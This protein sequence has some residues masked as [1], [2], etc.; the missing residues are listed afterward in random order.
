MSVTDPI[1]GSVGSIGEPFEAEAVLTRPANTDSYELENSVA[2][3][4]PAAL[5]FAIPQA[6]IGDF[7]EIQ[8]VTI[9]SDDKNAL[10]PLILELFLLDTTATP[11]ADGAPFVLSDAENDTAVGVVAG[12]TQ[13]NAGNNVRLERKE[14]GIL[15]KLVSTSLFGLLKI[16]GEYPPVLSEVYT[17][18][19]K[20]RLLV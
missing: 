4:S 14:V 7:V 15:A 11:A 6:T 3:A 1:T 10:S 20:G 18:T 2:A 9:T 12:F 19:I 17:I 5:V 8:N 16:Q 13:L